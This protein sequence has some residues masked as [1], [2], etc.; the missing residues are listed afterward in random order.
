MN[1]AIDTAE[2]L[3]A[4][5][6]AEIG[7]IKTFAA[8]LREEQESLLHGE[9]EKLM[10]YAERKAAQLLQLKQHATRRNQMVAAQGLPADRSG[11]QQFLVRRRDI[12]AL[13][14]WNELLQLADRTRQANE[15]NG[16]IIRARLR[17]NQQALATL[18][19]A[20]R[21]TSLYGADGGARLSMPG[22][23]FGAA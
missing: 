19:G 16:I 20:V 22:R 2:S 8:L 4:M 5:L 17:H 12:A 6:A 18:S 7:A 23:Q 3:P 15:T 1:A 11:M 10:S 14:L 13:R 9:A 21:A